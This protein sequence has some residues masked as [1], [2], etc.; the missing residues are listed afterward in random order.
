MTVIE[1]AFSYCLCVVHLAL[2]EACAFLLL[3]RQGI[4]ESDG[5]MLKTQL[6][7]VS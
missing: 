1:L 4:A 2:Y 6:A 3:D 7:A 5:K